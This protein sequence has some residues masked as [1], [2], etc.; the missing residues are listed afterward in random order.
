MKNIF[1]IIPFLILI[2]CKENSEKFEIQSNNRFEIFK[3]N[4]SNSEILSI[5]IVE[6][7]H[8]M[9]G[10]IIETVKLSESQKRDF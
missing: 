1:L 9:L 10:G 5:D 7:D 8:P 4:F 3:K 2:S 6:I